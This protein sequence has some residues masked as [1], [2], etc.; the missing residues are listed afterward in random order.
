MQFLEHQ[1]YKGN[2]QSISLLSNAEIEA[3]EKLRTY[4]ATATAL[5]T[6]NNSEKPTVTI[7]KTFFH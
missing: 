5:E 6:A 3:S 7:L 1:H 4:Y 2:S